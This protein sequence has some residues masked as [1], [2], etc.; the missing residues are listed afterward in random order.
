MK[1]IPAPAERALRQGRQPSERPARTPDG[2]YSCYPA[3][4]LPAARIC[5]TGHPGRAEQGS[6]PRRTAATKRPGCLQDSPG[7]SHRSAGQHPGHGSS[8]DSLRRGPEGHRDCRP[9]PEGTARCAATASGQ[10]SPQAEGWQQNAGSPSQGL[11]ATT[12]GHRETAPP[13]FQG[14]G[15]QGRAG[16]QKRLV[17][18]RRTHERNP[19]PTGCRTR[20]PQTGRLLHPARTL[21]AQPLPGRRLQRRARPMQGGH[22]GGDRGQRLVTDARAVCG[23]GARQWLR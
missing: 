14:L 9:F 23:G 3:S 7:L 12:G 21:V 2:R 4:G 15:C 6:V 17:S 22:A 11:A 16:S 1:L 8:V 5:A 13:P 19:D 10:P 18:L 20:H